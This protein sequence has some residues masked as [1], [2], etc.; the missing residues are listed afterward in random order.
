MTCN[1]LKQNGAPCAKQATT[2]EGTCHQ[3]RL[4]FYR[5]YRRPKVEV[6][7]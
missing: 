3:H 4:G 1:Q 7:S 5:N 2:P 6:K